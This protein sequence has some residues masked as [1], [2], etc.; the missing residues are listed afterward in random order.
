MFGQRFATLV[1]LLV[2]AV[3]IVGG[4]TLLLATRPAP[5]QITINPPAA[6]PLPTPT[7]SPAP[8]QVYVTGAVNQPESLVSL[9]AGS[10]VAA[11]I[12]AAG[13]AAPNADLERINLAA[14]LR[15]GD[16]V[17]VYEVGE[18][19]PVPAPITG[20]S[21][22]VDARGAVVHVNTAT[23]EELET[24][25]GIGPALAQRIIDYREAN[26][27]FTTLE[28]LTGVSGIGDRTVEHLAGLVT[29]D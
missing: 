18:S 27:A 23:L 25:P 7:A 11:A 3:A 5:V 8:L 16:Q 9:P 12:T 2:I 17:R 19:V 28:S 15:D 1:A 20:D 6:T 13:G 26:G 21:T 10:R 4:G 22:P 24:L 14:L 29:F